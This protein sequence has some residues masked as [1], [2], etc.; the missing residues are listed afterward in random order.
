MFTQC[1]CLKCGNPIEFEE[2]HS[3]AVAE[4][5]HCG[6]R[7]AL[8]IPKVARIEMPAVRNS[9][10]ICS[11]ILSFIMPFAGFFAGIYLMTKKQSGHGVTCSALSVIVFALLYAL[12]TGNW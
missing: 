5:P 9:T 10:I 6:Q 3:G 4:C 7:T 12:M 8:G 2:K 1:L 11:Y